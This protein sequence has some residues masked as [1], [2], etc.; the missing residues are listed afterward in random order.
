MSD[1]SGATPA[2]PEFQASI[3]SNMQHPFLDTSLASQSSFV[4]K[5]ELE[6]FHVA[7]SSP[8]AFLSL[9]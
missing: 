9:E 6:I 7:S 3:F 1:I 4:L 8:G 2:S 5:T